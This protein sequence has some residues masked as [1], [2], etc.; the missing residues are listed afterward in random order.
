[1]KW[2][3]FCLTA[4]F[5]GLCAQAQNLP[6]D[7]V[8]SVKLT[9]D[10]LIDQPVETP[11]ND[12]I[13]KYRRSS[14]YT[15]LI[16][17]PEAKFGDA[18]DS[19]FR[20]IPIP[21]KFNN[22][23][24]AVKSFAVEGTKKVRR[25]K[26][27]AS[28]YPH[29]I[30]QF[31]CDNHVPRE[32]VAMWFDRDS[33]TGAFDMELIRERGNYDAS[34]SAISIADQGALGRAVLA[35]AGE[36]L[37]G[38]TFMLVNDITFIDKGEKSAK[39]GVWVRL[40]GAVA[41]AATGKDVSSIT[42]SAVKLVNDIDG[43]SVN[44]TTYLFRLKWDDEVAA[45][46]YN[47]Y[48]QDA[49]SL[50]PAR[51]H[52]FD[53]TSLFKMCYVGSTVTS[54]GNLASKSYSKSKES[55]MLKVC[56]RAIDKSIVQLQRDFDEFKVNVPLYSINED[57]TVAVQIGLK[58]GINERSQFDVLMP[59]EGE[60][61]RMSYEKIGRIQPLEDGIWDNRFGADED[62]A[63]Q[64][65]E[66]RGRVDASASAGTSDDE[67]LGNVHLKASTFKVLSGAHR[68]VPGCLVREV[69]IKR[70]K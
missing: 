58:E 27:Q 48:W 33:Q 62:A 15:V 22:H 45:T 69:T 12:A 35:D 49:A 36:E 3:L 42:D 19:A 47:D 10:L 39:A 57:G 17:R 25:H 7:S 43:F 5:A 28:S 38:K 9:A 24:L 52:A 13:A 65:K 66:I 18:I 4:G 68:I 8:S 31:V 51:R 53:T 6:L 29:Y 34:Q 44:I 21:D 60:D 37:I 61:G 70:D 64:A 41:G 67:P 16:K 32:L 30:E 59:V 50:D 46:F 55:Q 23:E 63:E 2:L 11:A 54:A 1:M 14:L 20:S 26:K 56:T 40:L